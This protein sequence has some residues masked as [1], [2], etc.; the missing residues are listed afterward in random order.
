MTVFGM[1]S[2]AELKDLL[3]EEDAK[4]AALKKQFDD[5]KPTWCQADSNAC[6]AWEKDWNAL[7][8]RYGS[9]RAKARTLIVAETGI[10]DAYKPADSEYL[11]V[12][13]AMKQAQ[14][15][16]QGGASISPGDFDDLSQRLSLAGATVKLPQ[17]QPKAQDADLSVYKA[18]DTALKVTKKGASATAK[19]LVGAGAGA[20]IGAVAIATSPA[21]I[22]GAA[23]GAL[24]GA[25]TA[26]KTAK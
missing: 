9:A 4:V 25:Y 1:Q 19:I 16:T 2:I 7:T 15:S 20:A 26:K 18:A 5:F 14:T 22:A 6:N 8:A 10:G 23:I 12:L 21:I 13:K 3:T 24:A 11:G 17:I